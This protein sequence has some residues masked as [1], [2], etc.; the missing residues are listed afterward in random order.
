MRPRPRPPRCSPAL[1]LL[2]PHPALRGRPPTHP[3]SQ[4]FRSAQW[5]RRPNGAFSIRWAGIEI[6]QRDDADT[7]ELRGYGDD[8]VEGYDGDGVYGVAW[9]RICASGVGVCGDGYVEGGG[10]AGGSGLYLGE[11]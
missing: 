6:L 10:D 3:L 9:V 11:A 7:L 5:R 1:Y 2:R 8:A 4:H